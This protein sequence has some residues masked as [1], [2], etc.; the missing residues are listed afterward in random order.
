VQT[1]VS[2]IQNVH[3]QQGNVT[4]LETQKKRQT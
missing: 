2:L 3:K 4:V 1:A